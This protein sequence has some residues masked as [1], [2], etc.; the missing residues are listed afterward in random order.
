MAYSPLFIKICIHKYYDVA[1]SRIDYL[2]VILFIDCCNTSN[3]SRINPVIT[4]LL[5]VNTTVYIP[6]SYSCFQMPFREAHGKAG[7]VVKLTEA[8]KCSLSDLNLDQLRQVR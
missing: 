3:F 1:A 8:N 7:E 2:L 5:T 6:I 4:E